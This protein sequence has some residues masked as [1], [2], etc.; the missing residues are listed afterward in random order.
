M[1]K[2]ISMIMALTMVL[3]MTVLYVGADDTADP[4]LANP[5]GTVMKFSDVLG[6]ARGASGYSQIKC[7]QIEFPGV[8]QEDGSTIYYDAD[9]V[10]VL[11]R[12]ERLLEAGVSVAYDV[13]F[14]EINN[15]KDGR[16]S[17]IPMITTADYP[18]PYASVNLTPELLRRNGT[19]AHPGHNAFE[20]Y[21]GAWPTYDQNLEGP[22]AT[23]NYVEYA[24]TPFDWEFGKWYRIV[25]KSLNG[26]VSLY[27]DGELQVENEFENGDNLFFIFYPQNVTCYFDN[28]VISDAAYDVKTGEGNIFKTIDFEDATYKE[29]KTTDADDELYGVIVGDDC[30]NGQQPVSAFSLTTVDKIEIP[31]ET[32]TTVTMPGDVNDDQSFNSKDVTALLKASAGVKGVTINETLSDVNGDGNVNNK[33]VAA[34]LKVI[35][36][37]ENTYGIGV[38]V[39][40]S[41]T[42]VGK[43]YNK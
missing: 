25:Y 4:A 35:A 11:E 1:K 22:E 36:G 43:I 7:A 18:I 31:T 10:T 28:F 5:S 42:I 14:T 9:G 37:W 24:R 19:V 27:C 17:G 29:S 30:F 20:C 13:M 26:T 15:A 8:K 6:D 23:G 12:G 16:F 40:K 39:E 33:D 38:G 32:I 21:T 41:T 3:G 2:F 34:M